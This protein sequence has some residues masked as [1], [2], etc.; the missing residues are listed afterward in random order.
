ML[1]EIKPQECK[2]LHSVS[3]FIAYRRQTVAS[4]QEKEV[5][6]W[7]G[8]FEDPFPPCYKNYLTSSLWSRFQDTHFSQQNAS[9]Q[10]NGSCGP[11]LVLQVTTLQS[12]STRTHLK[13][14]QD[15]RESPSTSPENQGSK[16]TEC[17]MI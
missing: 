17:R 1:E 4:S 13:L 6:F 5:K 16:N 10:E 8:A 3:I 9:A 12:A 15:L 11:H 7:P 2:A 14:L